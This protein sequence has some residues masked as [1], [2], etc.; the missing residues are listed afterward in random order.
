MPFRFQQ[1]LVCRSPFFRKYIS[2]ESL[3]LFENVQNLMQISKMKKQIENMC[4]VPV[5]TAYELPVVYISLRDIFSD[6]FSL[7]VINKIR[8]GGVVQISNVCSP[9]TMF[10]VNWSSATGFLRPLF[11]H[12]FGIPSFWKYMRYELRFFIE[13]VKN[14]I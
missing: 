5:I 10:L 2:Y 1:F 3:I 6:S 4:F 13:I 14:L 7:A 8:K 11:Q 12:V 9:L